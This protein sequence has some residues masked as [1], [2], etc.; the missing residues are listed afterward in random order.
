MP[1]FS[2]VGRRAAGRV[3]A[4]ALERRQREEMERFVGRL[5]HE[6]RSPLSVV[7]MTLDAVARSGRVP[8]ARALEL[9]S[10]ALRDV[11]AVLE[12]CYLMARIDLGEFTVAREAFE[13][14]RCLEAV[15]AERPGRCR[16]SLV[17]DAIDIVSDEQAVRTIVANLID[18]A[19]AYGDAERAV[20]VAFGIA[21][22]A[23]HVMVRVR[24]AIGVAGAPDPGLAFERYYRGPL[25][26][27]VTGAGLG[28][29]LAR[30]LAGLLGGTV[31]L[32]DH[33]GYVDAVVT[34]PC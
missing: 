2:R 18:N 26:G 11:D 24:N 22:D 17:G 5:V 30:S 8:P 1:G 20:E 12:R 31:T 14:R 3:A 9:A 33:G 28:L 16:V 23:D 7:M 34:L 32:S 21:A 29:N 4:D 6:L 25:A 27:V 15:V 13:L 19:C 10:I